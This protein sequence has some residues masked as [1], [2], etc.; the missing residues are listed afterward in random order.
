METTKMIRV[1]SKFMDKASY[2]NADFVYAIGDPLLINSCLDLTLVSARIPRLYGN[3][4][5]PINELTFTDIFNVVTTIYVTPGQ[6][7]RL[8]WPQ[9][10]RHVVWI[11]V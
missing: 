7:T 8:R 10:Y 6:Y 11:S 5:S 9:K 4:Y 3:I 2:G 1:N